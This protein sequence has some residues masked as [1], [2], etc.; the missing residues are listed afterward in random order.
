MKFFAAAAAHMSDLVAQ[1]ALSAGADQESIHMQPGGTEFS[2]ELEVAYRFLLW[3]RVST[4]LLMQ[5]DTFHDVDSAPSLYAAASSIPWDTFMDVG[6]TFS[7]TA[8]SKRSNWLKQSQFGALTVKDAIVDCFREK[9]GERPNVDSESPQITFH[10][11]V[12]GTYAALY[13]DLSGGALLKRGYRLETTGAAVKEHLAAAVLYRA[14]WPLFADQQAPLLDPFCGSGTIPIEAALMAAEI[15][16]GTLHLSSY[17]LS[18]WKG[19]DAAL[20]ESLVD[21]CRERA[22]ERRSLGKLPVI[23]GWDNDPE[24]IA[25]STSNAV[26]AGVDHMV[27]FMLKDIT[28]P[29]ALFPESECGEGIIVCDPPYGTRMGESEALKGLYRAA[30]QAFTERFG[31][32]HVSILTG[33]VTL[34]LATGLHQTRSNTLYNGSIEATLAHFEIFTETKRDELTERARLRKE[35]LLAKPLSPGAEMFMSR[36]KKN[37]RMLKAFLKRE[38][39]TSYRIYD[40]DMPEYSAA[41]DIY[42]ETWVHLQEYAPPDT[43]DPE[44]A[45]RRLREMVDGVQRFTGIDYERIFIKQ[46]RRQRGISQYRK[47]KGAGEATSI[48]HE[49]GLK[50]Y[51]NFTDYID[52]GIFLD[53]REVRKR[54]MEDCKDKR[55][56]NLFAYT[57]TATVHAAKGGACSTT[58]IDASATYLQ[59]AEKNMGL[60]GFGGMNHFYYK[61]DCVTWLKSHRDKYD[62]ILL[63]PPT[64]SNSKSREDIFDVQRDHEK[65]IHMT[66]VHLEKDGILYFST[67]YTK[68]MLAEGIVNYF[69]VTDITTESIPDD[70]SRNKRIHYCWMIRHRERGGAGVEKRQPETTVR[71]KKSAVRQ[72][73]K[74]TKRVVIDPNKT[75]TPLKEA[76]SEQEDDL[77]LEF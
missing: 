41:I 32:W 19:H 39:V 72:R 42:E 49:H 62:R 8:T 37:K 44:D 61:E 56:L 68:F 70:F 6:T 76:P 9:Q 1:E 26:R 48:M 5:I 12:D 51:V 54:I 11:H 36:L 23:H 18:G 45:Q 25:V 63:D 16:P 57:G 71:T 21:E 38:G 27:T 24:A 74:T 28:S 15:A 14:Q 53:H 20:W 60:N 40:A 22:Q 65:L 55:F 69:D 58:S 35:A 17:D 77:T 10:L 59:W 7:V 34:L 33:D 4:R 3:S 31:G 75:R 67:N 73:P 13:L 47:Q 43:I 50:F 52:T 46:R 30:G 66:M 2:G 29:K 64:F